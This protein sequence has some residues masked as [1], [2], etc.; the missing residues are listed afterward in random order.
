MHEF[1]LNIIE[2]I[3]ISTTTQVKLLHLFSYLMLDFPTVVRW[4]RPF[5]GRSDVLRCNGKS[6]TLFRRWH[7]HLF[8]PD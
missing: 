5:F 2:L 3:R 7:D 8:I 6:P 1:R 4:I